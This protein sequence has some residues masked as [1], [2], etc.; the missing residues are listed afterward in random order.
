MRQA[1]AGMIWGKQFCHYEVSRWLDGDPRQ[2]APP[3]QRLTGRSCNWRTLNAFD[4]I[5]MPDT[6]EYPWFAA[7]DPAFH[8]VTP[9]H[10]DPPFAKHQLM[11]MLGEWY[12]S[13]RE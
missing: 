11:L 6:W 3:G 12:S 5:S 9:S 8:C 13:P 2:P 10:V 7:W 1:F 4:V